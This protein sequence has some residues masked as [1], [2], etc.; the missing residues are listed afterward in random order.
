MLSLF[1]DS[2]NISIYILSLS[3]RLTSISRLLTLYIRSLHLSR[4]CFSS[5]DRLVW[6]DIFLCTAVRRVVVNS[7]CGESFYDLFVDC[8]RPRHSSVW[9]ISVQPS[10]CVTALVQI[11]IPYKWKVWYTLMLCILPDYAAQQ[12]AIFWVLFMLGLPKM[13]HSMPILAIF[14]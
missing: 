8:L 12:F 7:I 9:M 11:V 13:L 10:T 4:I 1:I 2:G 3:R 5:D 14:T 6:T